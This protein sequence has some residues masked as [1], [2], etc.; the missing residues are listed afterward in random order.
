M[1][2]SKICTPLHI[3]AHEIFHSSDRH[4]MPNHEKCPRFH[5]ES[6]IP[7]CGVKDVWVG[8]GKGCVN[9]ESGKS[10]GGEKGKLCW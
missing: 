4:V 5:T 9:G 8:S 1:H 7:H 3:A 6:F 10:V 2:H